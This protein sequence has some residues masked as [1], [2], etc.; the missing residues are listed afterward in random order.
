[1]PIFKYNDIEIKYTLSRKAKK[2]VN[3]R[4]KPNGE[5][6][7][8]APHRVNLTELEKMISEKADWILKAQ[9]KILNTISYSVFDNY[10]VNRVM[11]Q[12]EGETYKY[13]KR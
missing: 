5:V 12:V 3:F 4:I 7:I 8:S 11:F 2:N 9:E 6:C 10:D 13:I 1:M